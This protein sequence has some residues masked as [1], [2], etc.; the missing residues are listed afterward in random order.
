MNAKISV[1]VTCLEVIIYLL[2]NNLHDCTFKK[3]LGLDYYKFSSSY[4]HEI[5]VN[6]ENDENGTEYES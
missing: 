2:L 6:S 1:F 3:S 5:K 4:L